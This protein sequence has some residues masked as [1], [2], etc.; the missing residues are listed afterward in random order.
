MDINKLTE[1]SWSERAKH[2]NV[3]KFTLFVHYYDYKKQKY[4]NSYNQVTC[5]E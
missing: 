2:N 1:H 3:T 4:T 5:Y